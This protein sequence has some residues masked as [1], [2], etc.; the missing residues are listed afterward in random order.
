M[1]TIKNMIMY[2]YTLCM[3]SVIFW[4]WLNDLEPERSLFFDVIFCFI[5]YY[6]VKLECYV[7][8]EIKMKL[9][10]YVDFFTKTPLANFR[11]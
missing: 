8:L 11:V 2:D 10:N 9:L 3:V 1:N 6:V 4:L 7:E 5:H